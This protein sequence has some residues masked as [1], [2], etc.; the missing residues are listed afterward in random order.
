MHLIYSWMQGFPSV[1]FFWG[2]AKAFK[3]YHMFI[4]STP[5]QQCVYLKNFRTTDM[6]RK[7]GP[8]EG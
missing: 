7:T 4:F 2:K 6:T 5:I 1:T 3:G 8:T